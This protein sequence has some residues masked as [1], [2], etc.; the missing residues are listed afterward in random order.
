MACA[1]LEGPRH[2]PGAT[3]AEAA[4][5]A[6]EVI[7]DAVGP[8]AFLIA[9]GGPVL[10]GTGLLDAQRVSGDVAPF[11]RAARQAL[12][13]DRATPGVRNSLANTMTRAFMSGRL[14]DG[15]P[16]C[17]M[18]GSSGTK[19]TGAERRTL[20]SAIAVF[21]GSIMVSDDLGRWGDEE[22]EMA[23]RSFPHA[24]GLPLCPDLWR[25][26]VPGLLL[27][28]MSDPLGPYRLLLAVNWH[29]R[30]RGG[31]VRLADIGLAGRWHACEYWSGR[32][33]GETGEA[34]PLP[35]RQPHGC[36]LVRLTEVAGG[37]RLIGSSVNLSQ[38]AAE[39]TGASRDD[40]ALVL[41]LSSPVECEAVVT[42]SLPGAGGAAA[43][44]R[45]GGRVDVERLAAGVYRARFALDGG[46]GLRFEYA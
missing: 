17:L 21:G 3:R 19:L 28:E 26:E 9:A 38:G 7:R 20:A 14:F 35:A 15:D 34:I 22:L 29:G 42:V 25:N 33:L 40:G 45:K 39:L 31:E 46:D 18:T 13:R 41:E 11:W 10:L 2:D 16:D 36:A 23:R 5:R 12:L 32:Y 4:R 37:P 27:S 44:L 6:L 30:P 1:L 8:E 24:H 43:S